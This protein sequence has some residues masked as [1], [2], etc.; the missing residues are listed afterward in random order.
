VLRRKRLERCA[1][2]AYIGAIDEDIAPPQ[3]TAMSNTLA[4]RFAALALAFTVTLA[5]LAGIGLLA[6]LEP[7]QQFAVAAAAPR[8]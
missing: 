7:A 4:S 6:E 1:A 2:A 3:E 8:A 5:M